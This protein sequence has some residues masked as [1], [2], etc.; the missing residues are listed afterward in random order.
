MNLIE[1]IQVKIQEDSDNPFEIRYSQKNN[2]YE[3]DFI[4]GESAMPVCAVFFDNLNEAEAVKTIASLH[5]YS[6]DEG[7]NGTNNWDLGNL[8]E[9]PK[10][11]FLNL[12]KLVFPLNEHN[13]NRIIITGND[14]Y[15]ENGVIG[16]VV[17][18]MPN[19]EY[20]QIPSAPSASFFSQK[21]AIKHL[22]VQTGYNHQS[23]IQQLAQTPHFQ[24]LEELEFWDY[25]EFYMENYAQYC[26][27]V[28][29]YMKLLSSKNLPKLKK[30]TLYNT[31]LNDE[32]Q[33]KL[34]T[35]PLY[36]QLESFEVINKS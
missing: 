3:L 23:F 12:K 1:K 4:A 32:A 6:E 27:P 19:L 33:A 5:L 14:D 15:D 7:I 34:K 29:D 35:L 18:K 11:I 17:A 20:L 31:L 2:L 36:S 9:K 22:R 30:V 24:D 28:E 10:N 26:V 25:S 16:K 13:H 8:L 21:S